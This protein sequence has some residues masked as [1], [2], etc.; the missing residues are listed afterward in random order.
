MGVFGGYGYVHVH[1]M[2]LI[3]NSQLFQ[4][5]KNCLSQSVL[6]CTRVLSYTCN[7]IIIIINNFHAL[8]NSTK[9][10]YVAWF[11]ESTNLSHFT[12]KPKHGLRCTI[13]TLL[14]NYR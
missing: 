8:T 13:E 5:L 2:C 14:L 9:L 3:T 7:I 6:E 11:T 12:T 1:A 4:H 10:S